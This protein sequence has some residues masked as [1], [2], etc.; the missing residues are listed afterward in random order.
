[1]CRWLAYSGS[2]LLL[3]DLLIVKVLQSFDVAD[4][5]FDFTAEESQVGKPVLSDLKEG[6]VTL[7]IIYALESDPHS[8]DTVQRVLETR[9]LDE[10]SRGAILDLVGRNSSLDRAR[11][12]AEDFAAKA[13]ENLRPVPESEYKEALLFLTDYVIERRH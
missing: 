1:M 7:P 9:S 3:E 11:R 5:L 2:A 8:L 6:H 13:K 4:D 12:V 10:A